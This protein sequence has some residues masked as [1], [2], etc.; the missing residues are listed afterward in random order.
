MNPRSFRPFRRFRFLVLLWVS[1]ATLLRAA[2]ADPLEAFLRRREEGAHAANVRELAAYPTNALSRADHRRF[3]WLLHD[4]AWRSQGDRL[5]S[6]EV[7]NAIRAMDA[8]FRQDAPSPERD[9]AWAEAQESFG[10]LHQRR[11]DPWEWRVTRYG[12]ALGWWAAQSDLEA[13]RQR[14]LGILWRVSRSRFGGDPYW[15][16]GFE[17]PLDWIQD[18]V[19]IARTPA[20]VARARLLRAVAFQRFSPPDERAL[21]QVEDDFKAAIEAGRGTEWLDDALDAS[22]AWLESS[23][24]LVLDPQ[25]AWSRSGDA[26]RALEV[27]RRIVAE[28]P[29]GSSAARNRAEQRIAEIL[30]PETTLGV[31]GVF[32]PGGVE[33]PIHWRNSARMRWSL[34]P[35]DL[36]RDVDLPTSGSVPSEFVARLKTGGRAPILRREFA[37]HDDGSHNPGHTNISLR[38]GPGAGAYLVEAEGDAS[39]ARELLL[40]S[41]ATLVV[42]TGEG[43]VLVWFADAVTGQPIPEAR[44]RVWQG[45][46]DG[47]VARIES[48]EGETDASGIATF[49]FEASGG[50]LLATAVH[51]KRQAFCTLWNGPKPAPA[52]GWRILGATDR[53]AYRPG[54]SAHWK[55]TARVQGGDAW[56]T[57]SDETVHLRLRDARGRELTNAAVRLNAFGSAW[58][59]LVLGP[60]VALGAVSL[61]AARDAQHLEPIGTATLFQVEE[62]KLPEFA[63]R[64][65]LPEEATASGPRR[66]SFKL[67]ETVE[68]EIQADLLSGG[69]VADA[70]VELLIRSSEG[71]PVFPEPLEIPWLQRE[72][73]REHGPGSGRNRA[74]APVRRELLKTDSLGRARFRLE[75]DSAGND[76]EFHLEA[77]VTDASKRQVASTERLRVTRQRYFASAAVTRRIP[78][79]GDPVEAR[80]RTRDANDQPVAVEGSVRIFRLVWEETWQDPAGRRWNGSALEKRQSAFATWPPAPDRNGATWSLIQRGYERRLVAEE[81]VRTGPDGA[82]S[83]VFRPKDPGYY[84]VEWSSPGNTTAPMP[85]DP[86]PRPFEAPITAETHFWVGPASGSVPGYHRE[87]GLEIVLDRGTAQVGDRMPFLLATDRPGRWVLLTVQTGGRPTHQVVR[88]LGTS[89]LME[90]PVGEEHGP[91]F[92]L[93]AACVWDLQVHTAQQEVLVPPASRLLTIGVEPESPVVQPGRTNNFTLTATDHRGRPVDA[94]VS[95][96][97][98]DEAVFR[99]VEDQTPDPR[100]FFHGDRRPQSSQTG[101]SFQ[102]RSYFRLPEQALAAG[103]EAILE[104]RMMS[105]SEAHLAFRGGAFGGRGDVSRF[106]ARNLAAMPADAAP[107]MLGMAVALDS[108]Q[109][110][111][112]AGGEAEGAV[113]VRSDFRETAFWQPD[114]RT[115]PEGRVR[116]PVRLPDSATRWIATARAAAT[117]SRVG[118]GTNSM[119]TRLPMMVRLQTPR[120]LVVGDL[121]SVAVSVRNNTDGEIRVNPQLDVDGAEPVGVFRGGG[122][123]RVKRLAEIP[124][125][126]GGEIVE[127]WALRATGPG[128]VRLR[129]SARGSGLGDAVERS[130]PTVEHGIAQFAGLATRATSGDAQLALALPKERKPGCTE[131]VVDVTPSLAATL[132]DA[133]PYLADYPYGCTEQTLSRFLPAVIVR[134]TLRQAGLDADTALSRAFGGISTNGAAATHPGGRKDLHQLDA[135]VAAGLERLADFQHADGGW[136]WWKEGATDA[137]MT[138]YVVWGLSLAREAGIDVPGTLTERGTT[139]LTEHVVEQENDPAMAAWV[140]HA[141]AAAPGSGVGAKTPPSVAKALDRMAGQEAEMSSY[142]RALAAIAFHRLGRGE[143][144]RR[145][146]A[147]LENGVVLGDAARPGLG[148]TGPSGPAVEMAHWGSDTGW[149][150][151]SDGPVES[152]AAVLRALLLVDPANRLALPAATWLQRDRRGAQWNNTRDTALA[153]MALTEWM[154]KTGETA[155]DLAFRLEMDG[156]P[157]GEA[158]LRGRP[159]WDIRRRFTIPADRL[160]SS[161]TIRVVRTAG[162]SPIHLSVEARWFSTEEPVRALGHEIF[163]RR[164]HYRLVPRETLLRGSVLDRIPL[165]DGE[166]V[167]SGDRIE[168]VLTLETKH[169]GEYLLL[170]DLKPAGFEA[171]ETRSGQGVLLRGI[172]AGAIRRQPS[173]AVREDDDYDGGSAWAHA[174]WRDRHAAFFVDR[175]GEGYWELRTEFRAERPGRFHT[176]PARTEAMY[177]PELRANSDEVHIEVH[178]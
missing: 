48:R 116:I 176:L 126:A 3:R 74:A 81:K 174:E 148:G 30:R 65:A 121:V 124:V 23:G 107:T 102:N 169:R 50:E 44:V 19:R 29:K 4:A 31:P 109:Q 135:M 12:H 90:L 125:P 27:Y 91:N 51:G 11:G 43:S 110:P 24:R 173:A 77:R 99:I 115:G 118:V 100:R 63:V 114:V 168:S 79:P 104:E 20:D 49:R 164:D 36:T 1:A 178:D 53:P 67:G 64:I 94:E 21:Y 47:K 111:G 161:N 142:S 163:L 171:V 122:L 89:R 55:V 151:W 133:L 40:V 22:A 82:G 134:N 57:P 7:E 17:L 2:A 18:A 34:T 45:H 84:A 75:T 59:E 145:W 41:D 66:R 69:P 128:T 76:L 86:R 170:E 85:P 177:V 35:V 149:H 98:A 16:H 56:R 72:D 62:Y 96:A 71:S 80:F 143:V 156:V 93:S 119:Q 172:K 46:H 10:D 137:W 165:R 144:A 15:R 5:R 9:R 52:A 103:K 68:F 127:T 136:G 92:W 106:A 147:H 70:D 120:F 14:Y 131:V 152:T 42:R 73:A 162:S 60:E 166:A 83:Q 117:D 157:L 155:P 129:A 138:A 108:F 146:V 58:G 37:T 25:G 132:L 28:F 167:R 113:V 32:L 39:K 95:F 6:E 101:S 38:P 26:A 150:R 159:L 153:L 13:A 61:E 130:L 112:A 154:R 175:I 78:K 33:F 105:K 87:G 123:I 158:D 140:L 54:D 8:D 88:I 139:W 97:V 160:S 141:L